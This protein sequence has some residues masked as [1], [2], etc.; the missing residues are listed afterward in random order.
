MLV[1]STLYFRF[2][3]NPIVTD[4]RNT[5]SGLAT[6]AFVIPLVT[7]FEHLAHRSGPVSRFRFSAAPLD[8]LSFGSR[9]KTPMP[10]RAL[11]ENP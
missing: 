5:P 9:G 7:M 8:G 4:A 6:S 10:I 2:F 3:F 11:K 1:A